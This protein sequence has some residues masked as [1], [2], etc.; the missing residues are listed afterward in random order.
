MSIKSVTLECTTDGHHKEY[1]M[2]LE[3]VG[4]GAFEVVALWGKIG[5]SLTRTV[6]FS[7]DETK[8]EKAYQ[9]ILNGQ[10]SKGYVIVGEKN[11]GQTAATTG[12]ASPGQGRSGK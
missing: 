2:S 6:K 5:S 8:A 1:R 3:A 12:A 10:L 11:D 9:K 7:G 4:N